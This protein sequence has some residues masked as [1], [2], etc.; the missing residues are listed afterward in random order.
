M[1]HNKENE[2]DFFP[3]P[4]NPT[5]NHLGVEC[6]VKIKSKKTATQKN[7]EKWNVSSKYDEDDGVC[8]YLNSYCVWSSKYRRLAV[9]KSCK[10]HSNQ[11]QATTT[12]N[13][14]KWNPNN[15]ILQSEYHLSP[16]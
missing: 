9:P 11:N 6:C 16:R 14:L 12:M 7:E 15:G 10:T 1:K 5:P 8:Y 13:L 2:I 3:L 4:E